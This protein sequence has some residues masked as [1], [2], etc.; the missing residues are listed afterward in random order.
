MMKRTIP[1]LLLNKSG[2][3]KTMEY[4]NP[5]Y[6]GDPIN[7]TRILSEKG[8][9]EIMLLNIDQDKDWKVGRNTLLSEIAGEC[10]TPLAFGGGIETADEAESLY[11]MGIE[12]VVIETAAI[13]SVRIL[14]NLANRIGAQAVVASVSVRKDVFGRYRV[15]D[16]RSRRYVRNINPTTQIRKFEDAGAGEIMVNFVCRDGQMKGMDLHAISHFSSLVKCPFIAAGGVGKSSDIDA[17]FESGADATGI[18]SFFV[19]NGKRKA[20]LV[21]YE[22]RE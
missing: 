14:T 12:K 9:D 8:A 5:V 1:L 13:K 15:F 16:W 17:A 4:K 19:F 11:Q 20:V 2:L 6:V 3:V 10:F 7:I 22:N 18:G 21:S